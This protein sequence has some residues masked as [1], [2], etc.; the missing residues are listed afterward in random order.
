MTQV[1]GRFF[2]LGGAVGPAVSVPDLVAL[3]RGGCEV[4][5]HGVGICAVGLRQMTNSRG[6]W[7][8]SVVGCGVFRA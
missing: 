1:G 6:G 8:P 4:L 3:G 5:L 7:G 2:S